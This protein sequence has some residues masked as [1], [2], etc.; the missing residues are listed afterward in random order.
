MSDYE[1]KESEKSFE[2]NELDFEW[3]KKERKKEREKIK[4]MKLIINNDVKKSKNYLFF[5]LIK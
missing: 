1:R 4:F 5:P 3:K 2:L